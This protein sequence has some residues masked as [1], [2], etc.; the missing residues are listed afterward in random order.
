MKNVVSVVIVTKDRVHDLQHCLGSLASQSVP[1][2]ELI[3]IDSSS[4]SKTTQLLEKFNAGVTFPAKAVFEKKLG[5]P[6]AYNRG[7]SEAKGNWVA[8]IDDDC[9]ADYRWYERIKTTTSRLAKV[10]A[11]R[12]K[13]NEYYSTSTVALTKAFIDEV[14]KIGAIQGKLVVDHEVLD[15]KNIVYNKAF[16]TKH[17]IQYD[18][19]LLDHGYGGSQDCELGMQIGKAGGVSIYDAKMIVFHKDITQIPKY[20]FRLKSTLLD[21]MVYEK[22]WENYRIGVKTKRPLLA[23]ISLLFDFKER[24]HLSNY[25]TLQLVCLI[26]LSFLYIK[27]LRMIYGSKIA[28]VTSGRT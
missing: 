12:G 8:F 4:D 27:A 1:P 3:V 28:V 23:K 19:N 18:V 17:K 20:L 13:S 2:D 9:V 10:S 24:Y 7:L 26:F 14:G 5:Y 15:S 11:I 22:K 6:T 25:K 21:H 16:L